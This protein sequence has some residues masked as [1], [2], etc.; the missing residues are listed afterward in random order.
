[1]LID[2]AAL[3]IVIGEDDPVSRANRLR[4]LDKAFDRSQA[5]DCPDCGAPGPH[6]DNGA[7][8]RSELT[9]LCGSCGMCFDAEAV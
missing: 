7:G 9:Y 6:D 1:M 4:D 8:R 5:P 3:R 2:E